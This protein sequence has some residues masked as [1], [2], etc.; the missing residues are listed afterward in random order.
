MR[1]ELLLQSVKDLVIRDNFERVQS[2]LN[3]AKLLKGD[4]EFFEVDIPAAG[5]V[6]IRHGL[7]FVPRDILLLHITGDHRLYFKYQSFDS[8][9]IYIVASGPCVV[10]F[11]A[12]A[13]SEKAY[14]KR[15]VIYPFV[16]P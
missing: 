13:T 2:F 14:N 10:R 5:T 9:N 3:S 8:D 15:T 7:K 11:F 6:A 4:W 16:A 12:G 1:L